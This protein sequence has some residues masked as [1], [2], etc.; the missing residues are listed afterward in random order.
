MDSLLPSGA[1]E[2]ET[3]EIIRFDAIALPVGSCEFLFSSFMLY[4]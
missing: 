1:G 3:T 4:N 2:A